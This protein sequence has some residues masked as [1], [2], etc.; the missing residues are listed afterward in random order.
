[1]AA[2][3][4]AFATEHPGLYDLAMSRVIDRAAVHAAG[5]PGAAALDA[6]IDSFGAVSSVELQ[7]NCLATLHGVLALD[8]GGFYGDVLDSDAVYAR[9]VEM[10]ILLLESEGTKGRAK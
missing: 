1:M 9:A 6:V 10:V 5:G 3:V 4:R 8:R 7:V 2:A